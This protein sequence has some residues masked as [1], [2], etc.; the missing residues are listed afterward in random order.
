IQRAVST[1]LAAGQ[2]ACTVEDSKQ[3]MAMAAVLDMEQARR[4]GGSDGT[5]SRLCICKPSGQK[6]N[7]FKFCIWRAG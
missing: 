7:G 5:G 3:A 2:A 4:E 1:G 6:S